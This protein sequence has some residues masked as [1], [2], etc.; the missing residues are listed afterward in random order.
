MV[1]RPQR[2]VAPARV[3]AVA[4]LVLLSG[5]SSVPNAA[6]PV[7]WYRD[8]SGASKNDSLDK[9]QSNAQN[10]AA[11][12]KEPYPNLA[13][14]PEPPDSATSAIDRDRLQKG[15]IADRTNAEYSDEDLRAGA[16]APSL[17]APPP[18]PAAE[19]SEPSVASAS[20]EKPVMPPGSVAPAAPAETPAPAPASPVASASLPPPATAK[21]GAPAVPASA[22]APP[23]ASTAAAPTTSTQAGMPK[24][25]STQMEAAAPPA[26]KPQPPEQT[27]SAES[28][29]QSPTIP[30]VPA[31]EAPQPPPP[32]AI[33]A[34]P[35]VASNAP[36]RSATS[37][38]MPDAATTVFSGKRQPTA[39]SSIAVAAINFADGSAALT[40]EERD[41]LSELAAMQ[42]DQGGMFRVVGHAASAR[43][44][45][46]AE[47]RLD[48]FTLALNRAKAVAQILGSEGVPSKQ[49]L[50]EA[51]PSAAGD[52]SI[53]DIYFEH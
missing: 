35:V 10:L 38:A 47:Q 21:P 19:A 2:I 25:S 30:N 52:A 26:E 4:T 44:E 48:G 18:P 8:L 39:A 33:P 45:E 23:A 5:C 20:L 29:L 9:D 1:I 12:G 43:G 41:R 36:S 53:A 27:A 51:A 32:P 28:P 6:N 3:F 37:A 50:V 31:G 14:V 40:S 17:V 49:I 34:A 16:P 15:L 13:D 42:H 22:A 24:A 46:D 11:G 7:A